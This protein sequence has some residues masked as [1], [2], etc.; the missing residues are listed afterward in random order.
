M[1]STFR[2]P[3]R[4]RWAARQVIV[5]RWFKQPSDTFRWDE[6]LVE[7]EVDGVRR[8]LAYTQRDDSDPECGIYWHYVHEGQEVGPWGKLLEY[9]DWPTNQPGP[10]V[11]NRSVPIAYKRHESYPRIF[12]SYRRDDAEAYAGR[13]HETLVRTFGTENVFMDQ[14]SIRPGDQFPWAIQQAAAHAAVMVTLIGPKWATLQDAHGRSRLDNEHDFVRREITAALD[15][16]VTVIPI[17]FPGADVSVLANA[18]WDDMHRLADLQ[19]L[20]LSPRRWDVDTG[21]V[22]QVIRAVLEER[23]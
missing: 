1:S 13:L 6:P 5:T 7:L 19:A 20:E 21:E 16:G 3:V 17:M 14:F 2:M 4:E 10:T 15:R 11:Q 22:V 23:K 8:I 9:T 18:Y 12:L